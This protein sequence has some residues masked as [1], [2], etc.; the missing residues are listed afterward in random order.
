MRLNPIMMEKLAGPEEC[1]AGKDLEE[2]G[3]VKI[4][5]EEK[6]LIRFTVAGT[7][8]HT[9]TLTRRLVIHCDCD[10]YTH[11]G[12][13]RHAVAAWLYA[14]RRKIP[15][16]MMKKQAPETA[17]S[18]TEMILREMPAEANIRL[19]V[20]LALPQKPGQELRIGLRI[21]EKKLYVIKDIRQ[22]L[23]ADEAGETLPLGR[24]FTYQPE[25]MRFSD[26][27]ERLLG[28]LRKL[29]S[30]QEQ[31]VRSG[32]AGASRHSRQSTPQSSSWP[33][34]FAK[35]CPSSRA[36]PSRGRPSTLTAMAMS[37]TC[38]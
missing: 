7:V 20:T 15:E 37:P 25:W 1:A 21:G 9:V 3:A 30:A 28:L 38:R 34:G 4:A 8:P 29:C 32:G 14:D 13:C 19:E 36:S 16:S 24:D 26:D 12:C 35:T 18:L 17:A 27:D 23:S 5:E 2:L 11:K 22:F 33:T 31:S 10:V 6:G